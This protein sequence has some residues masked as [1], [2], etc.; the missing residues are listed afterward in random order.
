MLACQAEE[1]LGH[2]AISPGNLTK[3]LAPAAAGYNWKS[4]LT[5]ALAGERFTFEMSFSLLEGRVS[6]SPLP[7]LMGY[8]AITQWM[9]KTGD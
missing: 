5:Q 3:P 7:P 6:P 8:N 1:A 2:K 4:P 9:R